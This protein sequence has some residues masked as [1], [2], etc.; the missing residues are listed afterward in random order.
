MQGWKQTGDKKIILETQ[1][2]V[3]I[4]N[5]N[6]TK[7]RLEKC[8]IT[9]KDVKNYQSMANPIILG[10]IGVGAISEITPDNQFDKADRVVICSNL[11]CQN[12]LPC[13]SNDSDLCTSPVKLGVNANGVYSD[14]IDVPTSALFR[15]PESVSNEQGLFVEDISCAL[16]ILDTLNVE[17]GEHIAIFCD[18]KLGIILAQLC[19]YYASIPILVQ[20]NEEVRTRAKELGVFYAVDDKSSD[21]VVETLFAITGG[22]MCEKVVYLHGSGY[23][24]QKIFDV[25]AH[26][27]SV[28]VSDLTGSHSLNIQQ[29]IDKHVSLLSSSSVLGNFPTAINLLATKQIDVDFLLGDKVKFNALDQALDALSPA[30]VKIKNVIVSVD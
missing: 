25:T 29:L 8:L 10:Q 5:P 16:N 13:R 17:K 12:C 28:C 21:T 19:L 7:V 30:Q 20:K 27:G 11:P 14:F 2:Y 4:E 1:Q 22:R 24:I 18:N 15:L 26:Y 6:V 9:E 23:P 3:K